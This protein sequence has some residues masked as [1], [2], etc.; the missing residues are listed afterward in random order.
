M[1]APARV[2]EEATAPAS[3][4]PG[5][6]EIALAVAAFAALCVVALHHAPQLVEPD[7]FAYR[8]SIIGITDGHL[9]TLSTAQMQ[10]LALQLVQPTGPHSA[11][12]T[13][14]PRTPGL[15]QWSHLANG[16]W[17]SEKD[18]GY[19]FLAAPFQLLGLI[20]LAPLCYGALACIA[21]F[22]GAR[23]W[24]GRYGGAVAV[25]LFCSSGAAL[26]FAW[27]DYMPTFTDAS[28]IAAGS[29]ALLWS[30]L[31]T[32]APARRR[33]A[34]GLLGFIAIEAAVFARYTNVV[35]LAC[36]VAAV[37]IL[38]WRRP[39][40]LPPGAALW[41]TGSALLFGAG[42]AVFDTLVYSGPL[43]SGYRSGEI[44]FGLGAVLPNVRLM[45]SHLIEAMPMLVLGFAA[46][47]GIG[48]R[49]ATSRRSGALPPREAGDDSAV[50]QVPGGQHAP[51]DAAIGLALSAAW[52]SVWGLY[53]AYD[54]TAEP[55]LS[56]LQ[57]VRFYLP[58]IG[59]IALLGA[60]TLTRLPLRKGLAAA[61]AIAVVVMFGFGIWSFSGT[62]SSRLGP[63]PVPGGRPP[64][65]SHRPGAPFAPSRQQQ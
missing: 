24:L 40:L 35:V 1:R 51:Q 16:R 62:A 38:R 22:A 13:A 60:W 21:L 34:A 47:I 53:A 46:L 63:R 41:W 7:D 49:W 12:F 37:L 5:R 48:A 23:R 65:G 28:L 32:D 14:G 33:T 8:A 29:G 9:L 59:P 26:L 25:G 52:L 36:A 64:P 57:S 3:Q 18:P 2:S 56:T 43:R 39:R 4:R 17:I 45:P 54:W 27:R 61:T 15:I 11:A 42:V 31:A 30:A 55:G 6:A 20:R 50:A 44:R 10:A 58:A 19:P